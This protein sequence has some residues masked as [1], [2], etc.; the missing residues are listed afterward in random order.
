MTDKA[1]TE[2]FLKE[3]QKKNQKRSALRE[4]EYSYMKFIPS[5]GLRKNGGVE[6]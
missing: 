5:K 2:K 1:D 6:F 3:I 4:L